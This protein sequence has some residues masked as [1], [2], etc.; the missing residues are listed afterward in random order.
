MATAGH[1]LL[2]C[3]GVP[4]GLLGVCVEYV[5]TSRAALLQSATLHHIW[6]VL[7]TKTKKKKERK[8]KKKKKSH[9][10]LNEL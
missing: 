6:L 10:K 2:E 1:V 3:S 8:K 5:A 4:T 9:W 7:T